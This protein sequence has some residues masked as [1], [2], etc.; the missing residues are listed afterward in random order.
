M[1]KCNVTINGIVSRTASMRTNKEGKSSVGRGSASWAASRWSRAASRGGPLQLDRI[2]GKE[3]ASVCGFHL[4]QLALLRLDKA[5]A[6]AEQRGEEENRARQG[7][8]RKVFED[9]EKISE[10]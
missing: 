10:S 5:A 2:Q 7:Q 6:L 8:S 4:G 9:S 1:I 3:R